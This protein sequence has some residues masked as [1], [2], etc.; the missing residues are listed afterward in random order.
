[1]L[2]FKLDFL[3]F[4][5]LPLNMCLKCFSESKLFFDISFILLKAIGEGEG[6][7][8]FFACWAHMKVLLHTELTLFTVC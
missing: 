4:Y 3:G 1:M 6:S 2:I 8:V 7:G 5:P